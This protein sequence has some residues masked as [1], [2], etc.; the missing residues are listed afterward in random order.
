MLA[1]EE[2]SKYKLLQG[3]RFNQHISVAGS[4]N[5]YQWY[6]DEDILTGQISDTLTIDSITANDSGF[7]QLQTKNQ[8]ASENLQKII[9][10]PQNHQTII[11][12]S[13]FT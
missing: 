6:K 3:S 8:L 7:Y 5:T 1:N 13:K 9:I 11:T 10:T 4:G 2:T 12:T